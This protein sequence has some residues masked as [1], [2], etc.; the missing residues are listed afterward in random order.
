[1]RL[2]LIWTWAH[3]WKSLTLCLLIAFVFLN[4]L[5]YRH[6]RSM[7][8]FVRASGR[9]DERPESLPLLRKLGV[10]LGGVSYRRA[11]SN[12]TPAVFGLPWAVHTF[13]SPAGPLEAWHVPHPS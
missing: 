10:L 2:V 13:D 5:A 1:M 11:E 3:P 9:Q 6:A 7:T 4:L 12:A 8:H